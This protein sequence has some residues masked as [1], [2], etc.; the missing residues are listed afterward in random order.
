MKLTKEQQAMEW[1]RLYEDGCQNGEP[2]P[3]NSVWTKGAGSSRRELQAAKALG[4]V[5]SEPDNS[6][7]VGGWRHDITPAGRAALQDKETRSL[8]EEISAILRDRTAPLEPVSQTA[9]TIL[10]LI[11]DRLLSDEAVEAGARGIWRRE[12]EDKV[13]AGP[14]LKNLWTPD[15][16]ACL[17]AALDR[18]ETPGLRALDQGGESNG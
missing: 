18:I 14:F 5:T 15:A 12:R 10:S 13:H 16:R 11:R 1:L 9:S 3:V 4:F 17:A 6:I 7:R 8:E 2:Y